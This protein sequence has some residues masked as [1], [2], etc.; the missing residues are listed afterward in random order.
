MQNF[1]TKYKKAYNES[2]DALAALGYDAGMLLFDAI[3]RA[4]SVEG[5]K[6]RGALAATKD[7][8]GVTGVISIDKDRNARKSAV[9]LAVENGKLIYRETIQP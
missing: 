8:P 3:K 5:A 2:P 9:I 6:I 4:K 1:V 7:F